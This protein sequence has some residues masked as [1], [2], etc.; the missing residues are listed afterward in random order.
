MHMKSI[1]DVEPMA[2]ADDQWPIART[3]AAAWVRRREMDAQ[4]D[5]RW[6][7]WGQVG[8][9]PSVTEQELWQPATVTSNVSST[10]VPAAGGAAACTAERLQCVPDRESECWR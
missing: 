10:L 9:P 3:Q 2:L 4:T 6:R 7:S 8:D 1:Y 5:G